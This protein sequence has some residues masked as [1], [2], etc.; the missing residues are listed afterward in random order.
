MEDIRRLNVAITRARVKL[1]MIGNISTLSSFSPFRKLFGILENEVI[2]RLT[3]TE[4][5]GMMKPALNAT[6][7]NVPATS[8]LAFDRAA[9]LK[10]ARRP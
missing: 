2:Y 5:Q 10:A 6:N 3:P 7:E 9:T 1:I 8:S 4:L